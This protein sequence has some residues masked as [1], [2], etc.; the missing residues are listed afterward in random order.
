M[1]QRRDTDVGRRSCA[2]IRPA[3]ATSGPSR[4][5]WRLSPLWPS[6][7]AAPD[8]TPRN[9][10]THHMPDRGVQLSLRAAPGRGDVCLG[11]P[12]PSL[13]SSRSDDRRRWQQPR[14]S[15]DGAHFDVSEATGS[16]Q[17]LSPSSEHPRS[18]P[19]P[20][21]TIRITGRGRP[22][23]P[24]GSRETPVLRNSEDGPRPEPQLHTRATFRPT[25]HTQYPAMTLPRFSVAVR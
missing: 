25:G 1:A 15:W 5:R 17:R 16:G 21:Q 18:A 4:D 12:A 13:Y 14:T 3:E 24:P 9:Q 11:N 2:A 23:S 22:A 19:A 6:A 10:G 7:R 8:H 20:C